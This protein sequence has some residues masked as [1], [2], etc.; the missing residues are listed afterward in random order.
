MPKRKLQVVKT[1]GENS[2][3][4]VWK[5]RDPF[6][7][8]FNFIIIY[9]AK[10]VPSMRMKNG[11]LQLTGMKIGKS[12]SIGLAAMFDIFYP[13]L[14]EIG[15]NSIIGYNATILAH[16][17]LVNEFRTGRVRIGKDAMV[18]ANATVLAGVDIGNRATVSAATLVDGDVPENGFAKGNPMK[19][20][21]NS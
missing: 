9:L 4:H 7:V 18:G 8:V 17:F 21:G 13:E 20:G 15:E 6:R 2:L 12:A 14:I 1:K 19:T 5:H 11:L 16:E 10:Y 3:R